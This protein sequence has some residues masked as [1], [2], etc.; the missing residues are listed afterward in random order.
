MPGWMGPWEIAIIV[1]IILLIFGG[2]L[3]PRMGSKL[4]RSLKG[5]KK[6]LKE[7]EQEFKSAIKEDEEAGTEGKSDSTGKT[8]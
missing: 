2:A 5:L 8:E 3:L 1:V 7:S 4:G 6:G